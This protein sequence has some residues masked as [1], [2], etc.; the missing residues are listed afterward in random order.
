MLVVVFVIALGLAW[1]AARFQQA[2]RQQAA[3]TAI[4][5]LGGYVVYNDGLD[6]GT[7]P[8]T[9]VTPPT[10]IRRV[11]GDDFFDHVQRVQF[12]RAHN[13]K[14]IPVAR[15]EPSR[16]GSQQY[17]Q[18]ESWNCENVLALGPHFEALRGLE[19][20]SFHD[21]VMPRD[22]LAAVA[23]LTDLRS[24]DLQQTRITSADLKHLNN[25]AKL[26]RLVL[27]RTRIRDDGL[28]HLRGMDGLVELSLGST[29]IGDAG[30]ERI[31]H[32]TE[33]RW[34]SLENTQVTD[35]GVAHLRN[36]AKLEVLQ[37][38]LTNTSD[39]SVEHLAQL[40][41]LCR[42]VVGDRVSEQ[43][44]AKLRFALPNCEIRWSAYRDRSPHLP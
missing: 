43:G 16:K 10:W 34:L 37:L 8:A 25:L 18:V 3:V 23:N 38:G 31:S 20:I 9:R 4:H 7:F 5:R 32:L 12:Q 2:R 40:T 36:L 22:S 17:E 1:L 19:S 30:V 14:F 41:A 11:V 27:R 24:L 35:E 26:E 28:V 39:A 29:A 44:I 13:P 33:L 42:L 6:T 21:T 15:I